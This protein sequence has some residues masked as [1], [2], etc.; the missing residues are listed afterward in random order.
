MYLND[1]YEN[2]INT[3]SHRITQ[4]GLVKPEYNLN[5][6]FSIATSFEKDKFEQSPDRVR[7]LHES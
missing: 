6:T 7:Y 5:R 4:L 1:D 3:I 2:L